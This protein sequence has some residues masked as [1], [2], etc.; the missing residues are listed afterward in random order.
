MLELWFMVTRA[1]EKNAE[2]GDRT[3]V[4]DDVTNFC[5]KMAEANFYLRLNN[6]KGFWHIL[7]IQERVMKGVGWIYSY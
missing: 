2:G 3:P 1:L 7:Y 4:G 5:P 6:R